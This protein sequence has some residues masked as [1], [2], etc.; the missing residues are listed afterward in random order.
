MRHFTTAQWA[1]TASLVT[2][3]AF[4]NPQ[5]ALPTFFELF[6][7]DETQANAVYGADSARCLL[8]ALEDF[9][10]ALAGQKPTHA[11]SPDFPQLLDGGT[12]FWKGACYEMTVYKRL[13]TYRL[14]DGSL[15]SGFIAGPS[16]QL[17]FTPGASM[18]QPIARTRFLFVERRAAT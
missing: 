13:T 2:M 4:A 11:K 14:P 5:A 3:A 10:L 16:L 6:G 12:T 15:V 9:N 18:T 8:D 7:I 1:V 17:N